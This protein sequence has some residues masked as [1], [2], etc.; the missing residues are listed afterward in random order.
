MIVVFIEVGGYTGVVPLSLHPAFLYILV[1]LP[2]ILG[3]LSIIGVFKSFDGSAWMAL[4]AVLSSL[5]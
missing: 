5:Y 1:S 2:V 4:L 3:I